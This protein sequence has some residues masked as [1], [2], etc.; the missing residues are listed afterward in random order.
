MK[1]KVIAMAVGIAASSNCPPAPA[2]A[3]D[4][5]TDGRSLVALHQ[6]CVIHAYGESLKDSRFDPT[7]VDKAVEFCESLLRD[8]ERGIIARTGDPKFAEMQL[9]K[10]REASRRG[11]TVALIGYVVGRGK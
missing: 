1:T 11:L 7:L 4:A 9:N 10:I 8:L 3:Q 2:H 5:P 6:T